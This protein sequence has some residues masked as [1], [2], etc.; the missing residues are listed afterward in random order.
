MIGR[1]RTTQPSDVGQRRD[2]AVAAAGERHQPL[3][4][5]GAVEPDQRHHIADRA[6][7]HQVEPLQ[8]VG[9]AAVGAVPP[10]SPQ[11]PVDRH[12]GHVG[13]A[14]GG[15]VTKTGK[16]VLAV[17]I[18]QSACRRPLGAEF[19]MVDHH[20]VDAERLRLGQRLEAGRAAVDRDD[21]AG[22]LPGQHAQRL[23]VRPIAL[24]QA[25]GDIDGG[26]EP[27]MAQEARKQRRRRGPVHVV[28]A[29]DG[30][31][32][33]GHDRIG[34][35]FRRGFHV[36]Q[37]R[38]IRHQCPQARRQES[39]RLVDADAPSRQDARHDVVHLMALGDG[40]RHIG[41]GRIEPLE[42]LAAGERALPPP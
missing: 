13:D 27:L 25:V 9:L 22:A 38:G 20:H 2:P 41:A 6:E 40:E 39:R 3:G 12:H 31:A 5:E 26:V 42:P 23:R 7:R 32:L 1:H 19:V 16:V 8:Q 15:E 35:A 33:A 17:G 30:D 11:Q 37:Q 10:A 29:E 21:Q 28:V 4:D 18:D 14:D 24:E 36:G 34:N